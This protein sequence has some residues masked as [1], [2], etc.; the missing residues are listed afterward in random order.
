[1]GKYV[2]LL[3]VILFLFFVIKK[4]KSFFNQMKLENIGYCLV[5]DKFEK[6]G[7]AM[8]VFQQSENEWTLVCPYKIY[9]ETPLLTRGSLTLKDGAFYSFES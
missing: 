7:K 6:D 8:V 3:T 1:M 9:L 4:V 2:I 5:V